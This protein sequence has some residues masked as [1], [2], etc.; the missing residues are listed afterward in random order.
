MRW[1][2]SRKSAAIASV[3]ILAAAPGAFATVITVAADG[4]GT[5]TDIQDGID[6][7]SP[8][9]TVTVAAGV[10]SGAGNRDLDFG[11]VPVMLVAPSGPTQTTIDCEAAGR[12][13][14]FGSGEDTSAVVSGFHITGAMADSGAGAYCRN[15]SGPK[16][17]ECRF[18]Q[19]NATNRGGGLC[20]TASSPVVRDCDFLENVASGGTYSYGGAIACLS[21]AAP[22]ISDT[23]FYGNLAH[24]VGGALYCHT[25]PATFVRCDF[26]SNNVGLYGNSGAGAA[27]ISTNGAAFTDCTFRENGLTETAV[28]GGLYASGSTVTVTDCEFIGNRAGAGCGIH[29]ASSSSGTVIGCTFADNDSVW[30]AA[31]G[32][33]FFSS[34]QPTVSGCTF[35]ASRGYHMFFRDASPEVEYCVLAFAVSG[36]AVYC[37]QGA[38]PDMHHCFIYENVGSDSLCGGNYHDNQWADPVFCGVEEG[39][40]TLCADSPCLPGV[41]WPSLVGA[42]GQGCG[43]CG[44]VVEAATW[45]A[46]KDMYR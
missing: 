14:F 44:S 35:V 43:A 12:G 21:S 33:S 30:S 28:G 18:E 11:G 7:A 2:S 10:Y 29:F 15:G 36:G 38:A 46:I 5:Y 39:N 9:D 31:A 45:G 17:V 4:S 13:F 32:I 6:A 42:H 3:L 25:S 19:N 26:A 24:N 37:D 27:L 34:S 16:F 20:C 1:R 41:T 22:V 8:G 40:Y 23:D